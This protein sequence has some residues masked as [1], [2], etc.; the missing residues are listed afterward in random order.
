M[1]SYDVAAAIHSLSYGMHVYGGHSYGM[2]SYGMH[3]CGIHSYRMHPYD[4]AAA[5]CSQ[6]CEMHSHGMHTYDA[7]AA[8][9]LRLEAIGECIRID[10]PHD[11]SIC[12]TTHPYVICTQGVVPIRNILGV[13]HLNASH[14]HVSH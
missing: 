5:A 1:H 14:M 6:S 10:M 13:S 2:R 8:A 3:S 4:A 12:H 7:A 11:S 9:R